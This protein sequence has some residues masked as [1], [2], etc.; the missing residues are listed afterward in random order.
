MIPWPWVIPWRSMLVLVLSHN[1]NVRIKSRDA[2]ARQKRRGLLDQTAWHYLRFGKTGTG[3]LRGPVREADNPQ[4]TEQL[5]PQFMTSPL[6]MG[7]TQSPCQTSVSY[8]HGDDRSRLIGS[9]RYFV[10]VSTVYETIKDRQSI[11]TLRY[12]LRNMAYT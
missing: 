9:T 3:P 2:F 8:P 12:T 10:V 4:G 7:K 11:T 5:A 1:C 6:V